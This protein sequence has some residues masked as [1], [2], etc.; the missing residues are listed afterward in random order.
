M[1]I[2]LV[3]D[4]AKLQAFIAKGLEE[5][6]FSVDICGDGE[7]A[8]QKGLLESYDAC[9]LDI[10]LPG[11]DGLEILKRWRAKEVSFPVLMLT[12]RSE[13]EDRLKGLELG[14]D[15]YLGKPFYVEELIARINALLRRQHGQESSI[16][17][18]GTL[19]LDTSLRCLKVSGRELHLSARE[20]SLLRYMM[21]HK[22]QTLTRSQISTHVWN[23]PFDSGTNVIDVAVKRLRKKIESSES[24]VSIES[25]RG[26]GYRLRQ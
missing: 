6:G 2:F 21:M 3:E 23:M 26:V 8:L 11:L 17:K 13:L 25:I 4:Q 5:Q 22:E 18:M 19:E 7:V 24:Q 14:A 12:A 9:I 16:L 10:M 1:R 15:D 20:F